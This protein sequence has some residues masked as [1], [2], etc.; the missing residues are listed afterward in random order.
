M[1]DIAA[2]LL[3]GG[4]GSR[5]GGVDKGA[6][7]LGTS[8]LLERALAA[9][10]GLPVVVVGDDGSWREG[11]PRVVV[12]REEPPFAGPA[13]AVVAGLAALP[14]GVREVLLLAVD[15]PRLPEAVPL[16]LA[17]RPGPDGVVAADE[18]GRAQWLLGRY[19]VEALRA[20]AGALG[21]AAGL[22]LR[23]LTG[24]LDVVHLPLPADLVQDVDTVADARRAGV[25]LPH[26]QPE[27]TA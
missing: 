15:V 14:L 20:A 4:R 25:A 12:V 1:D 16:L 6:L 5:L 3:T 13:A 27:E 7:R 19:R 11:H 26:E 10:A 18:G 23:A 8:T 22:P 17:A 21:D 2:V 9:L 24:A